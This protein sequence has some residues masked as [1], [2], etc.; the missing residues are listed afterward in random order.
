LKQQWDDYMDEEYKRFDA[1][2]AL[3]KAN[4]VPYNV[5]DG[6]MRERFEGVEN[7]SL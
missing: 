6:Q 3:A 7:A 4:G 1:D 5:D 2:V